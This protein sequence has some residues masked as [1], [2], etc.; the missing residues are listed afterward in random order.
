MHQERNIKEFYQRISY[1]SSIIDVF[2][3]VKFYD[4]TA[5]ISSFNLVF[6]F[7]LISAFINLKYLILIIPFCISIFITLNICENNLLK[8]FTV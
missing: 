6:A 1:G 5:L 7:I 2:I 4:F 8:S 3:E